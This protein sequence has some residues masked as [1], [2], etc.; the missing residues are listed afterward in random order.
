MISDTLDELKS[1]IGKAHDSLKRELSRIRTGRANANILDGVRVDYYGQPTPLKQVASIS[2]PEPRM[3]VLKPF[4]RQQ[5]GAVEKAIAAAN[6]GVN[7]SNDGE[8]I[9]IPLPPLTEERRKEL[10]KVARAKGEDARV[11]IRSARHDTKDMLDAFQKDGDV[12]E[13]E[14]D[15]GRKEMEE[16]VKAG[17][18]RVDEIVSAKETDIMEV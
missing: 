7:P 1:S 10:V 17:N 15:R 11:A 18:S 12:G 5:I 16:I 2:I 9:R 8:I 13:D 4:E 6:L 14:A 3:I